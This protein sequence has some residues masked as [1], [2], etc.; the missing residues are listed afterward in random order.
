VRACVFIH[1]LL[2]FFVV[3]VAAAGFSVLSCSTQILKN[4]CG[5]FFLR[6]IAIFLGNARVLH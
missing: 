5:L 3:L 1:L 4:M 6:G 2:V